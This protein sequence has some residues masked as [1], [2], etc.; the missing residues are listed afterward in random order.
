MDMSV[1]TRIRVSFTRSVQGSAQETFPE[2]EIQSLPLRGSSIE[3][4]VPTHIVGVLTLEDGALATIFTSFDVWHS[5]TPHLEVHETLGSLSVPDP[6][7][8][9]GAVRVRRAAD[10]H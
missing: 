2:R 7:R 4:E 9:A 8:F 5:Q 6:N 10:E 3:V 1:G